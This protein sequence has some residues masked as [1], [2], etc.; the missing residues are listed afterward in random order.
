[1]HPE[2]REFTSVSELVAH[3][4]AVRKRMIAR[5][6]A[7]EQIIKPIAPTVITPEPEPEFEPESQPE[8]V[9]AVPS[10]FLSPRRADVIFREVCQQFEVRHIDMVSERRTINLTYPRHTLIGLLCRL[11]T[12]SLPRIGRY[13]GGRDH[14]TALNSRNRMAHVIAAIP[15]TD[16]APIPEWVAAARERVFQPYPIGLRAP[17]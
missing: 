6:I 15:L 1:M 7:F 12:W 13:I 11:T 5:G 17:K 8:E 10:F 14:T 16:E 9:T 3:Y 2:P 4:V